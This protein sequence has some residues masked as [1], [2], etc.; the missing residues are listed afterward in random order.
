ML[1]NVKNEMELFELVSKNSTPVDRP[2]SKQYVHKK[3][4]DQVIIGDISHLEPGIANDVMECEHDCRLFYGRGYPNLNCE[5]CFDH[6]LDHYPLM[7]IL[8]MGRQFGIATSHAFYDIP[9]EGYISIAD[10]LTFQFNVFME[11]DK[12]A[13]MVCIDSDIEEK[14]GT[15][16]RHIDILFM[17]EGVVCATGACDISTYK[18][19]LY[20]R[21]RQ[22]SRKKLIPTP[23]SEKVFIPTNID[24]LKDSELHSNTL[25]AYQNR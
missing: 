17:Q 20:Q 12:P 1:V 21:M 24:L 23:A 4:A 14:R 25:L 16:R 2:I 15:L 3:R 5:V 13:Y 8:E 22:S 10:A 6:P 7:M 19:G 11:L 18:K 9:L